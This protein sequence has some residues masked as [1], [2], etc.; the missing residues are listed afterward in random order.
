MV[1]FTS[2][3]FVI[4]LVTASCTAL[5]TW[6]GNVLL[7]D[8]KHRKQRR[9]F[10]KAICA[11]LECF[12]I[13]QLK[14]IVNFFKESKE[15]EEYYYMTTKRTGFP[16][17]E[18][19]AVLIPLV[20]NDNLGLKI[21]ECYNSIYAFLDFVDDIG[22]NCD[23]ARKAVLESVKPQFDKIVAGEGTTIDKHSA[24]IVNSI[25]QELRNKHNNMIEEA[26]VYGKNLIVCIE[27]TVC[28][29][30]D[31]CDKTFF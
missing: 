10:L 11:E 31:E 19:N 14:R 24:D 29:I 20:E 27:K 22:D 1:E 26:V 3:E 8:R 5:L 17:Y 21:V 9:M 18:N 15:A 16:V 6:L 30:K 2:N 28:E 7:E 25:C 12:N 13:Q 23:Q 4:S